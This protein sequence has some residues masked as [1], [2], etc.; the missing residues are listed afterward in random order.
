MELVPKPDH[1]QIRHSGLSNS[2]WNMA[3]NECKYA[4]LDKS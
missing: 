1:K 3:V 4:V 2:H